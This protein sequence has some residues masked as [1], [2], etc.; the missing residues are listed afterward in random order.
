MARVSKP[1]QLGLFDELTPEARQ[2]ATVATAVRRRKKR[3]DWRGM[4]AVPPGSLLEDVI[5][6]FE[7]HTNIS[8][9]IP[10]ATFLHYVS[11]ALIERGVTVKFQGANIDADVWSVVLAPSGGGKTWTE[12]RIGQGLGAVVPVMET[13]AAS[14]AKWLEEFAA[15]PRALWVRDEFFQLLKGIE[16]PGPMADLKDYLLRIYDGSKIERTTK[17]DKIT[18]ENPALSILGFTALKPFVDGMSAESLLDGFAQRFGFVLAQPDARRNWQD[19]PVW[20]VDSG[21]WAA[22]FLAMFEGSHREYKATK[23]AEAAFFKTFKRLAH[24]V[25]LDESFYRRVMWRAHKFALIYHLVR[26][27]GADQML[28]EEDYGWAARWVEIQLSDTAE[29]LEMCAKTDLSKA[30]DAA[31]DIIKRLRDRGLP[32]TARAIVS[33]TRLIP[34]AATARFVMD[35]LGVRDE[36]SSARRKAVA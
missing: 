23:E 24:G 16:Q 36:G 30:I 6:E 29:L 31:E 11:G 15:H 1:K 10:F 7:S 33:G 2:F 19:F 22:R 26:G 5:R 35:V 34:N 25:A 4:V 20:G 3:G 27:A 9:E 18:V 17:K 28:T 14:A 12:K 8:L 13:G 21:D 32:V